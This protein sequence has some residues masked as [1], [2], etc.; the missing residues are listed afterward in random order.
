[1]QLDSRLVFWELDCFFAMGFR[2]KE[3]E[4]IPGSEVHAEQGH[5]CL[6]IAGARC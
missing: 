2:E 6:V 3:N 1:M 5:L 4:H